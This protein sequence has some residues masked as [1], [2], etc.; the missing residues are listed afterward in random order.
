MGFRNPFRIQVDENDVAYVT[1]Y[2]P[3]AN[4]PQRGRGPSGVGRMEIVRK[5]SN[6]G[7][8]LCYSSKLGY[9]QWNFQRVR[10]GHHDARHPAGQ[11]AAADRLRQPERARRTTSRWVRDGGPGFEPGLRDD[12]RRSATRRSGT[13]TATTGAGTP[14]G[15]PCFGY[16]AT[17][18]G[19]DRAGLDDRVP[20]AVPGAYTGGVAPHGAVEVPLRR[21]QPEHEEVPALLRQLGLPGRVHARTRCAR[22]SS[23]RRTASS[24]STA[25]CDCG[26]GERRRTRRST[27]ECDNPMD[28]QFGKDG[29]LYLL[30][31]GDGFFAANL[32]RRPVPLGLRQGPAR[33]EGRAHHR[34]DRRRRC[35]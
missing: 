26:A 3:D 33:A 11:P 28:M 15:T 18:P 1:D 34:Q 25:S 10:A 31:Y 2:S 12:A 21:G 5:P 9:Y 30:T 35:R 22:S 4:T 27:F 13:R 29:S 16:Y 23:T 20:A 7:Y 8:P 6:Y 19:A 17:T 14:L 24:R 32:G